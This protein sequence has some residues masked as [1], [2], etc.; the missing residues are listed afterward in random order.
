MSVKDEL[1]RVGEEA[2]AERGKQ[3]DLV[4]LTFTLVSAHLSEPF[5][6]REKDEEGVEHEREKQ[7]WVGLVKLDGQEP[8]EYWLD[9]AACGKQVKY[10]LDSGALPLRVKLIKHPDKKG[11]P[12]WLKFAEGAPAVAASAPS[13]ETFGV[14]PGYVDLVIEAATAEALE[15]AFQF[16]AAGRL[17][18]KKDGTPLAMYAKAVALVKRIQE[19]VP[20]DG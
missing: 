10:L 3:N 15:D 19:A 11:N 16:D 6:V 18:V 4:N 5:K 17:I 20:F 12:Y 7:S 2:Y 8:A 1:E 13:T 14:Q 9:G